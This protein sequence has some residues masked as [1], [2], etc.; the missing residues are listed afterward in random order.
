MP[1]GFESS[2]VRG[3]LAEALG[4]SIGGVLGA[5]SALR[6]GKSLH[7]HGVVYES[8][9][10]I[11]GGPAAPRGAR[12]LGEPGEHRALVRFSRSLGVPRPI[13]DLLGM[14][15]RIP[16]AYGAGRHQDF[17]LVTSADLPVMHHVFLPARD[18]QQRP[19]TSSLP[20]RAGRARFLVGALPD[21]GSPRPAGEDEIAR[22]DAAAATG[23]LRFRLA[24]AAIGGRFT[25]V[26]EVAIGR[27]LEPEADAL[28][29]NPWNTGGGMTPDGV[30][31]GAR[32]RAYK[33][34]QAA[35]RRTRPDGARIQEAAEREQDRLAESNPR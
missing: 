34:S 21:P 25:P 8:R 18:A 11:A 9:L 6:R 5:V 15:I 32:D 24:V 12:L 22:L 7:P 13:P 4:A 10:L 2:P 31:N 29:F 28:R 1:P 14:S 26:G 20:Y 30:L 35:W 17:L 19:Y 27:R 16:D 3:A 33:L 23:R